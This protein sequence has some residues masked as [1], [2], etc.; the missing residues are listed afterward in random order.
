MGTKLTI[1]DRISIPVIIPEN[2][3]FSDA[4]IY[5][6]IRQKIKI[7]QDEVITYNIRNTKDGTGIEWDEEPDGGTE[8]EFT[9]AENRLI[10]K[11]FSELDTKAQVPTD[12]KFIALN[13]KFIP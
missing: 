11:A 9:S 6:D 12:P 1:Y 10:A 2:S 5:D 3:T 13:R 7:T 4:I 8:F